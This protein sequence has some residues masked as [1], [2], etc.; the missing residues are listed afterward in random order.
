MNFTVEVEKLGPREFNPGSIYLERGQGSSR[1]V[2]VLGV[3]T[4]KQKL[5][6]DSKGN[7][8][9]RQLHALLSSGYVLV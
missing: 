5:T 1:L 6:F 7:F 8:K 4:G 9:V 3:E 2:R